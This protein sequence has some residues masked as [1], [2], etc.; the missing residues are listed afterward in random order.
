MAE[1]TILVTSEFLKGIKNKKQLI[2]FLE[3]HKT[4]NPLYAKALRSYYYEVE[5]NELQAEMVD[6]QKWVQKRKEKS[7]YH[8]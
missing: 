3:Q 2:A 1:N 4:E 8:F 5:L 7:S 6:F